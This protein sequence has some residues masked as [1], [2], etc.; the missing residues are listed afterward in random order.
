MRS[1]RPLAVAQS[2]L[3]TGAPLGRS[4]PG[5]AEEGSLGTNWIAIRGLKR[6]YLED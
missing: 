4:S 6:Y 3:L 2:I 1:F 5:V